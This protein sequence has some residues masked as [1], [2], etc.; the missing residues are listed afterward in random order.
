MRVK[1]SGPEETHR[2]VIGGQASLG[3]CSG[4]ALPPAYQRCVGDK[5][6]V[7]KEATTILGAPSPPNK[8]DCEK[9]QVVPEEV[10]ECSSNAGE[11][12]RSKS[13]ELVP[14]F[15]MQCF[16]RFDGGDYYAATITKVSQIS[17]LG[18]GDEENFWYI[19]SKCP[20]SNVDY[21]SLAHLSNSFSALT[22]NNRNY[23][24]Q[25]HCD[26]SVEHTTYP[27]SDIV[28]RPFDAIAMLNEEEEDLSSELVNIGKSLRF[29]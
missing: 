29:A 11:D 17:S 26:L 12:H 28:L 5:Q 1:R 21:A 24:V 3:R 20:S 13:P 7:D 22:T 10:F 2:P 23:L 27:D 18:D 16:V 4:V 19:T 15:G 9:S 6:E 8:R 14:E 25:Y